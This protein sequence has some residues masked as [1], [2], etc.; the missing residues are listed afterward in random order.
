MNNREQGC[1]VFDAVVEFKVINQRH[2]TFFNTINLSVSLPDSR[3]T[4]SSAWPRPSTN[5]KP[6]ASV[7]LT[8]SVLLSLCVSLYLSSYFGG[9]PPVDRQ[10]PVPIFRCPDEPGLS[11]FPRSPDHFTWPPPPPSSPFTA[12]RRSR[13]DSLC[14]FEAR[15]RPSLHRMIPTCQKTQRLRRCTSGRHPNFSNLRSF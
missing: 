2:P 1:Q 7:S 4:R 14:R 10:D 15:D 5:P 12:Q 6:N 13:L 8:L 3:T 11:G 9:C